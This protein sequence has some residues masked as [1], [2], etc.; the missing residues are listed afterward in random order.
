MII[1]QL[2]KLRTKFVICH[3]CINKYINL[4]FLVR[5][6]S[7]DIEPNIYSMIINLKV[8]LGE[9]LRKLSLLGYIETFK[10]ENY[11]YYSLFLRQNA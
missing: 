9:Q 8:L 4:C 2:F 10:D 1:A 11:I 5:E 7:N 6:K 3:T